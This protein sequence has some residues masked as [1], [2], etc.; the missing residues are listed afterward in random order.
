MHYVKL[1]ICATKSRQISPSCVEVGN[2]ALEVLFS[3]EQGATC[4]RYGEASSLL[5][6]LVFIID[7]QLGAV[8]K[9]NH[10]TCLH[11]RTKFVYRSVFH[12][13]S[14]CFQSFYVCNE[15]C[16]PLPSRPL[17][18]SQIMPLVIIILFV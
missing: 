10:S 12:I 6:T 8:E 2:A 11:I 5:L 13:L 1:F 15:N 17:G 16:S 9:N 14:L 4:V 3:Q 7:H 18:Y